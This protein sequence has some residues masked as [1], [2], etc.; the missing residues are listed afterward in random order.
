MCVK[1]RQL[2]LTFVAASLGAAY[3]LFIRSTPAGGEPEA[4]VASRSIS[5]YSLSI[6]GHTVVLHVS[7]A[8]IGAAAAAAVRHLDLGVYHQMLRGAVT[9]GEDLEEKHIKPIVGLRK[10][11]TQTISHFSR[12]SDADKKVASDGRYEYFG[13]NKADAGKKLRRFYNII[14]VLLAVFAILVLWATNFLK[15]VE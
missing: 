7:L 3:Y 14:F 4:A 2:G 6:C 15:A 5:A 12:Y 9:F 10:G 8:I 13:E 11:M 1:S